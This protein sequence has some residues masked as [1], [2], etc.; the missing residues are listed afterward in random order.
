VAL[1]GGDF[2]VDGFEALVKTLHGRY[3]FLTAGHARRLVRAYGTEAAQLLGDAR[4]MSDLGRDFGATLTEAEVRW[5]MRHEYA[6]EAADV[7]WRRTRLG[8]KMTG[9]EIAAL[10]DWMRAGATETGRARA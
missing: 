1:P 10:D 9:A 6:R 2:A 4:Q 3:P 8:L 5:Q 7:V